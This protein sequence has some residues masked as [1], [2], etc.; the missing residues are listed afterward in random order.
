MPLRRRAKRGPRPPSGTAGLAV[1]RPSRTNKSVLRVFGFDEGHGVAPFADLL[2]LKP[3]PQLFG[4]R[5]QP[6]SFLRAATY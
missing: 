3:E 5:F 6:K 1:K 2:A 4:H